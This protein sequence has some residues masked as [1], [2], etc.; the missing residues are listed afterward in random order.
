MYKIIEMNLKLISFTSLSELTK[1]SKDLQKIKFPDRVKP[2]RFTHRPTMK[3]AGDKAHAVTI[4]GDL[5]I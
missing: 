4:Y 5:I 3:S 1:H 2:Y